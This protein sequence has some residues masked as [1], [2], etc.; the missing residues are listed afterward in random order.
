MNESTPLL[1]AISIYFAAVISPGPNFVV[2]AR[3]ALIH[4]RRAGLQTAVGVL[5]GTLIWLLTGL[6]GVTLLLTRLPWL[7]E[8]IRIVGAL[9]LTYL[10]FKILYSLYQ[11]RINRP[12]LSQNQATN[13]LNGRA[14]YRT[15]LLTNL[16]NP[17][18]AV[19]F[20][21]FFTT[22]LDPA[23]SLPIK[24][25]IAMMMV[26]VSSSWY[27]FVAIFF[28]YRLFQKGYGRFAHWLDLLF[29]LLLL[30]LAIRVLL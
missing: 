2:I 28:S 22:V 20:L 10:A 13:A 24:A 23:A 14:A 29:A 25:R 15:G 4:S 19:F 1:V 17:A 18:S 8:I 9:Y 30:G 7:Y 21:A 6:F 12:L 5:T 3:T 11:T 26:L 27:A 16:S